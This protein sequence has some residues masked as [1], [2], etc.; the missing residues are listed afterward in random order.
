MLAL[1]KADAIS[2]RHARLLKDHWFFHNCHFDLVMRLVPNLS[3][4]VES[5]ENNSR[6]SVAEKELLGRDIGSVMDAIAEKLKLQGEDVKEHITKKIVASRRQKE[7]STSITNPFLISH[8]VSLQ[9]NMADEQEDELELAMQIATDDGDPEGIEDENGSRTSFAYAGTL[10]G[11]L[12]TSS[13]PAE[14]VAKDGS[15]AMNGSMSSEKGLLVVDGDTTLPGMPPSSD[16]E[17]EAPRSSDGAGDLGMPKVDSASPPP[18]L[19]EGEQFYPGEEEITKIRVRQRWKWAFIKVKLALRVMKD[20]KKRRM[21]F[22]S[23]HLRVTRTS[24]FSRLLEK[25]VRNDEASMVEIH[26][27][28]VNAAR[29]TYKSMFGD[30]SLSADPYRIL[31]DSLNIQ[32]EAI[33]TEVNTRRPKK[34]VQNVRRS[35][36]ESGLGAGDDSDDDAD[37]GPGIWAQDTEDVN[38]VE[39]LGQCFAEAWNYVRSTLGRPVSSVFWFASKISR[40]DHWLE[41]SWCL[42]KRDVEIVIAY[43]MTQEHLMEDLEILADFREEVQEPMKHT[44]QIAKKDALLGLVIEPYDSGMFLLFEHVLLARLIV[45]AQSHLL[46]HLAHDGILMEEDAEHLA[47]CVIRPTE[48]ALMKY[49]PTLEQLAAAGSSKVGDYRSNCLKT[50]LMRFIIELEF[51]EEEWD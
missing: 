49:T 6:R 30:R 28:V 4:Q 50:V 40:I 5:L 24:T 25:T 9:D 41:A 31:M 32:E 48:K 16:A 14:G 47:K 43:V 51:H 23:N 22:Q 2:Q 34:K 45:R 37:A 27:T 38:H 33:S 19:A 35:A 13:M 17:G 46:E 42:L 11:G 39:K 15:G 18:E 29:A 3:K 1:K 36:A 21:S 10:S 8:A 20:A 44:T 26:Q 7:D 12:R